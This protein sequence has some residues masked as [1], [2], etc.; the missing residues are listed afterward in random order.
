MLSK[1]CKNIQ[2]ENELVSLKF[3]KKTTRFHIFAARYY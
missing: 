3:W 2:S 1:K